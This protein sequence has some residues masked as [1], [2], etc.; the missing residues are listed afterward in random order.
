MVEKKITGICLI[1]DRSEYASAWHNICIK[2]NIEFDWVS[3]PYDLYSYDPSDNINVFLVDEQ[4]GSASATQLGY[5]QDIREAFNCPVVLFSVGSDE[6]LKKAKKRVD[7]I[8]N[9]SDICLLKLENLIN[10]PSLYS[11][12]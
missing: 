5:Y 11:M 8:L 2:N 3:S 6:S 12:K 9:K 10:T 4:F 1:D 7:H